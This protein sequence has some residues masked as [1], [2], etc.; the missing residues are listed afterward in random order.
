MISSPL[1]GRSHQTW[2]PASGQ[3]RHNQAALTVARAG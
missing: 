2:D 1:M 3:T